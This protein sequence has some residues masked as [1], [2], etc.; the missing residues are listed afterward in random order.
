MSRDVYILSHDEDPRFR[1]E[2]MTRVGDLKNFAN[3]LFYPAPT[4]LSALCSLSLFSSSS[5]FPKIQ[6]E[7]ERRCVLVRLA[8][9]VL[10]FSSNVRIFSHCLPR[11]YVTVSKPQSFSRCV[12]Q[13]YRSPDFSDAV[14]S[15]YAYSGFYSSI[16]YH[17][18]RRSRGRNKCA[19]LRLSEISDECKQWEVAYHLYNP[20]RIVLRLY[21]ETVSHS[22]IG[23]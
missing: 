7:P 8:S 20:E 5:G 21:F 17:V 14:V 18:T 23:P 19:R 22:V 15:H 16:H 9:N 3:S 2:L 12:F 1:D 10:V 6:T 11:E 4:K 13:F